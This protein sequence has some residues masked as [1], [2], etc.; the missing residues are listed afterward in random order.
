M[1]SEGADGTR[2]SYNSLHTEVLMEH[3]DMGYVG[4]H[5]SPK[6]APPAIA[7]PCAIL[8]GC[9]HDTAETGSTLTDISRQTRGTRTCDLAYS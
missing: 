5:V 7:A 6:V 8:G 1:A 4:A 9:D 3:P 2:V